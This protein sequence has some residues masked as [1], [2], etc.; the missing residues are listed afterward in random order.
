M[1]PPGA[2]DQGVQAA[3]TRRPA[4]RCGCDSYDDM[5]P[6][7]TGRHL[8]GGGP[9]GGGS[10][11][12]PASSGSGG[13]FKVDVPRAS[14]RRPPVR[15]KTRGRSAS[16]QG[17]RWLANGSPGPGSDRDRP[18]CQPE[19]SLSTLFRRIRHRTVVS[20]VD[21]DGFIAAVQRTA[22]TGRRARKDDQ[23]GTPVHRVGCWPDWARPRRGWTWR[24]LRQQPQ[25]VRGVNLLADRQRGQHARLR[26]ATGDRPP[27]PEV[28]AR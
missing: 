18:A 7:S 2:S 1:P 19:R 3:R 4:D 14:V 28:S 22:F 12:T 21:P 20:L 13:D 10:R 9:A 17:R 16:C 26:S 5:G 8:L 27:L 23:H 15:A 6:I 11:S 24:D 25:Q